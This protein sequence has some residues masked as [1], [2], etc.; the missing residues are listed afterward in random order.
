[1][2]QM[3]SRWDEETRGQDKLAEMECA[4]LGRRLELPISKSFR[5]SKSSK[6]ATLTLPPTFRT[7][8]LDDIMGSPSSQHPAGEGSTVTIIPQQQHR[9]LGELPS[10]RAVSGQTTRS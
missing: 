1:M 8:G 3:E 6:G 5:S 10:N 4:G 2:E 7:D 9:R